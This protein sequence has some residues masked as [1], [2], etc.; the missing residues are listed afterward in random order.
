MSEKL[1]KGKFIIAFYEK[2]DE[3]LF[4]VFSNTREITIA[5]GLEPTRENVIWISHK[6]V[7]AFRKKTHYIDIFG[8]LMKAY[9]IPYVDDIKD[10]DSSQADTYRTQVKEEQQNG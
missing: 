5:A 10:D 8:R 3:T 6:L 4:N 2:D 1:Y 7:R 9:D